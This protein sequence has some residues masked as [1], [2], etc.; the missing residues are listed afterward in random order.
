M[1]LQATPAEEN[2]ILIDV[3]MCFYVTQTSDFHG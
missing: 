2:L 1:A 3:E